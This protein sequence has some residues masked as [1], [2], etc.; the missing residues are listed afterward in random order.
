M[1]SKLVRWLLTASLAGGTL[2][3]LPVEEASAQPNVRDHRRKVPVRKGGIDAGATVV[4]D[5]GPPKAA[6]PAPRREKIGRRRGFVWVSGHWDWRRGQ[7]VWVNGRWEKERRGKRWRERRWEQRGDVWVSVDGDWA[8]D[9]PTA[10]PPTPRE[11]RVAA[12]RG[13]IW[14][15]G[16]WDWRNGQWDWVPGHWERERRGKR[17]R[18]PRWEL[19]GNAWV[20]I[21]GEWI[22]APAFPNA[23]PPPPRAETVALKRGHVWVKGR[24]DWRNGDWQ[25]V[26]G[27]WERQRANYV[28]TEGRWEQRNGQW[29]WVDGQWTVAQPAVVVTPPPPQP[30][31]AAYPTAPP[32]AP[33]AENPGTRSGFVWIRGRWDWRGGQW[34]WIA[35]HWERQR[36]NV[37]YYDGRWEPR[38]QGNVRY[39]VWIE[40]GWR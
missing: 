16:N 31:P 12:R 26:P 38:T 33:Q 32:P 2:L 15:A 23:A 6:P 8:D 11:E 18:A 28:W 13:F 40:G 30:Q 20:M 7:W 36:A 27:H 1:R 25:W 9:R 34:T 24:W 5:I 21:N 17:W 22:D 19:Q 29:T 37:R 39:Y 3:T 10:A 35:G 4:V 14:V